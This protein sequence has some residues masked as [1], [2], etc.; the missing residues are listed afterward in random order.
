MEKLILLLFIPLVCFG[1]DITISSVDYEPLIFS[2]QTLNFLESDEDLSSNNGGV[3][4]GAFANLSY[5]DFNNDGAKDI[6]SYVAGTGYSPNYLCVFLWDDSTQKFI[7]QHNYLMTVYG[8][9][10]FY[11]NSIGDVNGDGLTDIYV[12]M[13]NYHGEPGQQPEW[14]P[15]NTAI[16]N[17][18]GHLFL[19]NGSSFDSQFIDEAVFEDGGYPNYER[20]FIL[21]IDGDDNLEIIVPSVNQHPENTPAN[22]FLATKYNISSDNNITHQFI[23]PWQDTFEVLEENSGFYIIS[24]NIIM[25]EH[26][27]NIYILYAGDEDWSDGFANISP[28]IIIYSKDTNENDEFILLDKFRLERDNEIIYH[29]AFSTYKTFYIQDLDMDGSDEYI[30]KMYSQE[31]SD[32]TQG[33]SGFHIFDHTGNEVASKWFINEE[34]NYFGNSPDAIYCKDL[35]NDG[36]YDLIPAGWFTNNESETVIY[37]NNGSNFEKKIIELGVNDETNSQSNGYCFPV[38]VNNNGIYELLK[39]NILTVSQS[40]VYFDVTLNNLDYS[41]ALG[42]TDIETSI[43]I[44]PNPSFDYINISADSNLEAI[45]YDSLGKELIRENVTDKID[46]SSLEKGTYI[47]NLTDGINTSTHKIIKE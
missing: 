43:K 23:Y 19:N 2:E 14:Y 47:L 3:L 45:L 15:P 41:S 25:K 20:G 33:S 12:P 42:I 37:L 46:I 9:P 11:D 7:E 38:D 13:Q 35:N 40:E 31:S 24:H 16:H 17:M 44:Y 28:E 6:V 18:P 30:I 32:G 34:Y 27:D 8:E 29:A 36:L 39:F 4:F 1:Q 26:N 5:V 22:N 21:D 10:S